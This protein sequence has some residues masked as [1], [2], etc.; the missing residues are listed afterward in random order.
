MRRVVNSA[1]Q[2]ITIGRK[3]PK[4]GRPSEREFKQSI[5]VRPD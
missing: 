5:L 2:N 3:E 4:E 1:S